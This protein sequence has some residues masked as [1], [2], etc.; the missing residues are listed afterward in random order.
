LEN[1]EPASSS[2]SIPRVTQYTFDDLDRMTAEKWLT[3]GDPVPVIAISTT[4]QG[5]PSSAMRSEPNLCRR[6]E[7]WAWSSLH[8]WVHGGSADRPALAAW[9]LPRWPSWVDHVNAAQTEAEL[10][11]LRRSVQRGSPFGD[12]S[13]CEEVVDR[14]GLE[15]TVRPQGRPRKRNGS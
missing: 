7:A 6:A 12:N 10:A 5:G 15:S 2:P 8:R 3:S 1:L 9:P 14:L 4:T 13:W 11:V